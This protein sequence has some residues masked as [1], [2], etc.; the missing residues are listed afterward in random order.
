MTE[1][2]L[3]KHVIK[4]LTA[5]GWDVYQE[6]SAGYSS[7]RADIVATRSG[8]LW[9]I[10]LKTSLSLKLFD[11][12]IA[13]REHAH[14]LSVGYVRTRNIYRHNPYQNIK[15]Y[16]AMNLG[17]GY[18]TVG[19]NDGGVDCQKPRYIKPHAPHIVK[20][21]LHP[22]QK[23]MCDSG[24]KSGGYYTPFRDTVT[25]L[26]RYVAENPGCT[27]KQ[28][29]DTIKHHYASDQTAI[30]CLFKFI[31][32]KVIPE[33]VVDATKRPYRLFTKKDFLIESTKEK[34]DE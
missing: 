7:A 33:I 9:V 13:W 31:G 32:T 14:F 30:V 15:H 12:I 24:S 20:N 34:T 3:G 16:F 26:I 1:V 4:W 22:D 11:Q 2:E 17:L 18:F 6:V 8:A 27:M 21:A 10:E 5:E 29:I 19:K 23:T 25:Q 28:A